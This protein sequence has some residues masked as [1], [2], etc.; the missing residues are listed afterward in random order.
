MSPIEHTRLIK[1]RARELGFHV[2]GVARAD[3][4][5]ELEHS[6]FRDHIA[7]GMHGQL[8]YLADNV[9]PRRSVDSDAILPGAKSVIC[10]GHRYGRAPALEA[11]DAPLAKRIA[12]YARGQDYH[13]HLRRKLRKLSAYV[14]TLGEGVVS[15]P[16][17]DV[18]P[19]MERVWAQRAGL[20]FVGKNGLVITPGQGS[21]QILGEVICTLELVEDTPMTERCGSC[22]RCL[23]ACPTD[24]FVAPFVLDPRRCISYWTIEA[25][26]AP[27]EEL[28]GAVGEHLF[29]CDICQEVCPFNRTKM[30]D[31]DQTTRFHPLER[32]SEVGLEDLLRLGPE[33][34]ERF[35]ELTAGSPL[36]RSRREGLARNAVLAAI[37]ELD[38]A[39]LSA[40]ARQRSRQLVEEARRHDDPTVRALAEWGLRADAGEAP[41]SM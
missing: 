22:T 37:A 20:G 34:E 40:E 4:P 1:E 14:R 5:I 19:V 8:G 17:C 30:P 21:Y 13:N 39:D 26:G 3:T 35:A 27:P 32:W 16:I 2:V 41:R 25:K 36:K 11:D 24:A 9:E 33:D 29:G 31:P 10:V 23:D 15:R 28:R 12:R 6:R 7:K 38:N 18:E